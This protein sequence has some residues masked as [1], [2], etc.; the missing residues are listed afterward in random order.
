VSGWEDRLQNDLQC[1]KRD[2]KPYSKS[3]TVRNDI[4]SLNERMAKE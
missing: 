2:V 1:A 3:L 4:D